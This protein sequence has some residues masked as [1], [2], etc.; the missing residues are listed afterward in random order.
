M[1]RTGNDENQAPRKPLALRPR[2][3]AWELGISERHLWT[4]TN[5]NKI[6]HVKLGK[7]IRYI[8]D[9]LTDWLQK[10]ATQG[11]R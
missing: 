7:S 8:S 2:E 10:Q 1:T 4:L 3:A 6:P 9:T 5:Q 11:K